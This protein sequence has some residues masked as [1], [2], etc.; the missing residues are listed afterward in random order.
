MGLL[1]LNCD[2]PCKFTGLKAASEMQV[3]IPD[4]DYYTLQEKAI[5]DINDFISFNP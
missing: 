5:F 1:N 3:S 4:R 2:I